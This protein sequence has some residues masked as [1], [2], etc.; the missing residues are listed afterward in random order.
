MN[1][2]LLISGLIFCYSLTATSYAEP[3]EREKTYHRH[4]TVDR[5][6]R[7][8]TYAQHHEDCSSKEAPSVTF[9]TRPAHGT[10]SVRPGKIEAGPSRLGAGDCTG[11]S[12]DGTAVYYLPEKGF[13]GT[14]TFKL[15]AWFSN[16]TTHDTAIVDV[17]PTSPARPD[18]DGVR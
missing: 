4:T 15:N 12:L 5:E 11:R 10:L 6:V 2:F 1:R 9:P 14:D 16:G 3:K 7:V 8:A 18:K 17:G 13:T